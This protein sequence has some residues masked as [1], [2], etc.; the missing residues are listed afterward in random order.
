MVN[1][2]VNHVKTSHL[3]VPSIGL[4]LEVTFVE[5]HLDCASKQGHEGIAQQR[6]NTSGGGDVKGKFGDQDN[7]QYSH[8][9]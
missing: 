7:G 8:E 6:K 2:V 1:H 5:R 3:S 4:M 9:K